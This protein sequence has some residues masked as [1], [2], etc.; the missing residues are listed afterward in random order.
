MNEEPTL[1]IGVY[2]NI[3]CN[4][5]G[6]DQQHRDQYHTAVY[7]H[8]NISQHPI[9]HDDGADSGEKRDNDPSK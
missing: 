9:H 4:G 1:E 7:G 2:V 3:V 5:N 6:K 8:T